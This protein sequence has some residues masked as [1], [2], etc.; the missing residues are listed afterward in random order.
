MKQHRSWAAA[1][2]RRNK[3]ETGTV[4]LQKIKMMRLKQIKVMVDA[5]RSWWSPLVEETETSCWWWCFGCKNGAAQEVMIGLK[6]AESFREKERCSWEGDDDED[7]RWRWLS[8]QLVSAWAEK[9]RMR[10]CVLVRNREDDD[11]FELRFKVDSWMFMEGKM[12]MI[13]VGDD[14][15]RETTSP[16]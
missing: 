5:A 10:D 3:A 13:R 14:D 1:H 15:Q 16:K 2:L 7:E 9:E 4:L 12:M 11:G 8:R 6:A